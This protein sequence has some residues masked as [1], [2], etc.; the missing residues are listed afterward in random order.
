MFIFKK[1]VSNQL[2]FLTILQKSKLNLENV[3]EGNNFKGRDQ[4]KGKEEN[5]TERSMKSKADSVKRSIK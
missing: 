2:S 4:L 1:K 5:D 3:K